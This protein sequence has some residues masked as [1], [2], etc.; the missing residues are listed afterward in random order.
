M[1]SGGDVGAGMSEL[2]LR[3]AFGYVGSGPSTQQ[4]DHASEQAHC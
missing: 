3:R 4:K 1:C 2:V